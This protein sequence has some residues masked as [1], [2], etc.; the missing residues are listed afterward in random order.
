[1]IFWDGLWILLLF[2]YI[3]FFPYF[4]ILDLNSNF[5]KILECILDG[6]FI[7]DIFI[8]FNKAY[9]DISGKLIDS[10]K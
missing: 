3:S 4:L 1:M 6:F 2:Y 9:H 8:C 7:I 5:L 10:R